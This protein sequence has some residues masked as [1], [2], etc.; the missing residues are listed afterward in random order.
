MDNQTLAH[1]M[2]NSLLKSWYFDSEM[3]TDYSL[4]DSL[5]VQKVEVETNILKMGFQ[6]R[7]DGSFLK[8]FDTFAEAYAEYQKDRSIWKISYDYG[9]E[10]YR[11]RSKTKMDVWNAK[12]E[13]KIEDLFPE[14]ATIDPDMVIWIDQE[15]YVQPKPDETD[16]E[17]MARCIR[18]V[19][20]KKQFED[21]ISEIDSK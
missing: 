21:L 5:F 1:L 18:R 9:G 3:K 20:S 11:W 14:Y 17:Q 19:L 7:N 15:V 10:S 12:S 8:F 16:D 4:I 2:W 6:T 13:Q